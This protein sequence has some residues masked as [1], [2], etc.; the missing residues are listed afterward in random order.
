[1]RSRPAPGRRIPR[2]S[3]AQSPRRGVIWLLTQDAIPP[4]N[5]AAQDDTGGSTPGAAS[6]L[7]NRHSALPCTGPCAS[8]GS[9]VGSHSLWTAADGY[10]RLWTANRLVPDGMDGCGRLWTACVHLR[11]RRL[12]IRVPPGV[13]A[14]PVRKRLCRVSTDGPYDAWEPFWGPFC[15]RETDVWSRPAK[16]A[17][18]ASST[19]IE[20]QSLHEQA[21]TC[22]RKAPSRVLLAANGAPRTKRPAGCS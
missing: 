19:P 4:G 11:I 2:G 16:E 21:L 18:L 7:W 6:M 12:G 13:P 10:G 9:Q 15:F 1:M 3:W 14:R 8:V 20:R 17:M 5:L 22:R